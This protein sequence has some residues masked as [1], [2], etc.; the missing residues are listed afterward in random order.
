[1][2]RIPLIWLVF[3]FFF[4]VF[5]ALWRFFDSSFNIKQM[6]N[7]CQLG[8]NLYRFLFC[9]CAAFFISTPTNIIFGNKPVQPGLQYVRNQGQWP[10]N[11]VYRCDLMGGNLF[12][13]EE[14][15]VFLFTDKANLHGSL[16]SGNR[17][18]L[19]NC[20]AYYMT[21]VGSSPTPIKKGQ[22]PFS[23]KYNFFTGN[24]PAKW[25]VDVPSFKE[26]IYE[27]IYPGIDYRMYSEGNILKSDYILYP[28]SRAVDLLIQYY[29][30]D[31][32]F[33]DERG[34]LILK[35]SVN[36]VTEFRP[37]AYQEIDGQKVEVPCNYILKDSVLAFDFPEGYR[38]NLPLI[39]DPTLVFSTYSGSPADN[40]GS[41]ATFDSK[42]N[43]FLGGIALSAG[44]PTTPGAFQVQFGGGFS[45]T[46]LNSDVVITKFSANATTRLYSTYIGGS[47]N[48]V[49]SSL[50][51]TPEDELVALV[52]TGSANFPTTLNA[53][54]RTFNQGQSVA[55]FNFGL[56]F[57]NGTD[58]AII[59]FNAN[60]TALRGSTFFGGSRNE[61]ANVSSALQF[62][63]GDESRGDIALDKMGNIYISSNTT[64]TNLPGTTGR[65]QGNNAGLSDGLVASFSSDLS[66]LRW[67]TY[68]GGSRDDALY[69]IEINKQNIIIVC[70]GTNSTSIQSIRNGL[71]TSY[72]GGDSDGFVVRLSLDGSTFEG[73][74]YLGTNAYDQAYMIELDEN[75]AVYLFGQTQG[76]YPFTPGVYRTPNGTQFI[77]KL[78]ADLRTTLFSTTFGSGQSNLINIS[79]TAFLVDVCENI[80]AVGW[81]GV[82][83]SGSNSSAGTTRNM[84]T[85]ADAFQRITDGSDFYLINLSKDARDLIYATYIGEIGGNG[86]HVDG[87]TSRFDK[88]GVVYQAV[89]ASCGATNGFPTTFGV[90]S[91]ANLSTNCNMAGVKFRF[92]LQAL[93]IIE[94]KAEPSSGCAPHTTQFSFTSSQPA[95]DF[96]W[97]FGDGN[98]SS[99]SS[100]T[101]T[102]ESPGTYRV[103]LKI[104]NDQN[105]NPIDSMVFEIEIFE[106][107]EKRLAA[108]ICEGDFYEVGGNIYQ[109]NG[110]YIVDTIP[111]SGS[112]DTLVYLDLE[113]L[114][115]MGS[116]T[117]KATICQG[118]VFRI[119]GKVFESS[120]TYLLDSIIGISPCDSVLYLDLIVLS[121]FALDTTLYICPAGEIAFNGRIFNESGQ[122]IIEKEAD[123]GCDSIWRIAVQEFPYPELSIGGNLTFCPGDSTILTIETNATN[124]LWSDGKA[125]LERV[126]KSPGIY[127]VT[128]TSFEGCALSDSVEISLFSITPAP[129]GS[130]LSLGCGPTAVLL[131]IA[132][133][134]AGLFQWSGPGITPVNRNLPRPEVLLPGVYF[135][136][137]INPSGC[138]SIDSVVVNSAADPFEFSLD[139]GASCPGDQ[140]SGYIFADVYGGGSPPFRYYLNP[141]D[142]EGQ[143]SSRFEPLESG[144]YLLT[145]IDDSGCRIDTSLLVPM[146]D[147][148]QVF[149]E[150]EVLL[151]EGETYTI[152][153]MLIIPDGNAVDSLNWDPGRWLSCKDCLTPVSSPEDTIRYYL[154]LIDKYGCIS[155]RSI[156]LR[157]LRVGQVFIPNVFTP[158][159]DGINDK[160]LV[161]SNPNVKRILSLEIFD[162]WGE[163]V[164]EQ[165]N[166]PPNDP[167]FG[168][169]GR[170]RGRE[171]NPAVFVYRAV[172]EVVDGQIVYLEGDVTLFR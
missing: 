41:S 122:F 2:Y 137:F 97:G 147:T 74:T 98:T 126:I 165:F 79:P 63:Y 166:F 1:M 121:A 95:T 20:H 120:G 17:D 36:T 99:L 114:P 59:K 90:Y 72:R 25:A 81:G 119:D 12:L 169:D 71:H 21:W 13:E 103:F 149:L 116:D 50:Y 94:A 75:Q 65:A 86:D 43:M 96:F 10:S 32:L 47:S 171:M 85:T 70:G 60:G 101:H 49:L 136:T 69:G 131:G 156:F 158:N 100:P 144:N 9:I 141:G 48:E 7:I 73:G 87:G 139:L 148:I 42:G 138:V 19:V 44:Y 68:V 31:T 83:N 111:G 52:T 27:S 159:G 28:G 77:H 58:L 163:R 53:F 125:D 23:E 151:R 140:P 46:A 26:V 61:G 29:G 146:R 84:P 145:I 124:V 88:F 153:P 56:R 108:T 62:N 18:S 152:K 109:Q 115:F 51:C 38:L 89:C 143:E 172:A 112:C 82:V 54:D 24:D 160:L 168:W 91:R 129:V 39:I 102:F 66:Q 55:F 155:R 150:S 16:G 4:F 57:P 40:W 123:N 130:D 135:L 127:S 161:F 157:L 164:F 8:F 11:V 80:Y 128:V 22:F 3:I 167:E 37:F 30:L 78:S 14:R 105:C 5:C 67:A 118:E 92:D 107:P 15:L 35:T 76:N 64:S 106:S 154:E 45:G 132:P 33:I 133:T 162:R 93:L 117:I 142:P 134:V 113:V 6:K 34:D 170:F 104:Q 110:E